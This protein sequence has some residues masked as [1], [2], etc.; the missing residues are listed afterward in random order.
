MLAFAGDILSGDE[1]FSMGPSAH[2]LYMMPGALLPDG[3]SQFGLGTWENVYTNGYHALTKAGLI[4]GFASSIVLVPSLKLG[5]VAWFNSE[6]SVPSQLTAATLNTLIPVIT[7]ELR[8]HKVEHPLPE[9]VDSVVGNYDYNGVTYLTVSKK[10]PEQ[11]SGPLYATFAG[12]TKTELHYNEAY[13]KAFGP[14][15]ITWAFT[16][17]TIPQDYADSCFY[18]AEAGFDKSIAI[19]YKIAGKTYAT[20]PALGS[21]NLPK[22]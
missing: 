6:A 1:C 17:R 9:G 10:D 21:W 15:K 12:G 19:F 16:V 14:T 20:I 4:G 22:A 3:L 13:T 7:Q 2:E 18:E 8:S 11:K 5:V